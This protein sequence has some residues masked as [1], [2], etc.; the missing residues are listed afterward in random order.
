[1][2]EQGIEYKVGLLVVGA[3]A[4]FAAFV[5]VL[6][7]FSFADSYTV[8][9][10]YEFSGN[11][12]PGAPVKIS[13]IEVGRVESVD[14]HGGRIDER[15]GRRVQVR[16]Q[17]EVE[18]RA[19]DSIRRDAEFFINT[20][21]V[22]GEQYIEIVPGRDW[23]N[24]ALEPGAIVHGVDPPRTDLVVARLYEVLDTVSI[25]LREDREKISK[26]ISN[27]ADTIATV[28]K[29][30]S[31]NDEQ[32]AELMVAATDLAKETKTT[33]SKINAGLEPE[34]V[35]S[36]LRHT[37][38]LIANADRTLVTI[39]PTAQAFLGEATRVASLVTADRVERTVVAIDRASATAGKA[40]ALLDNANGMLTDLRA[41]KGT[42][43]KLLSKDEL[44]A[45]IREMVR[46]LK[47]NPW[48][49]FWKE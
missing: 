8:Y 39:T 5:F 28:D 26:M 30:L 35:A 41:G 15:T 1:M 34:M 9:V 29:I 7:N 43:G 18:E 45:D 22:L 36:T 20:A 2:K 37:D 3:I 25:V 33:L 6:G 14:F 38:S 42:A 10:D 48:K 19:R 17:L 16:V 31:E 44:Y 49:V 4:L 24:P 27:A 47:R 11:V 23:D 21:G 32:I 40:G 13:G 46:D 12:Q